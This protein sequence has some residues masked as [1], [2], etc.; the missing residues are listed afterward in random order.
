VEAVILLA[1]GAP[2]NLE[3]VEDYVMRIR[4]GRPLDPKLMADIRERYRL[5]GGSPL[6]KWTA[7]QAEALQESLKDQ[8]DPRKVYFGMRYSAPYIADTVNEMIRDGVHSATSICLAPQFSKLTIG[9][10][11]KAMQDA[12]AGREFNF[13]LVPTYAKHPRL[14]Q[15]FASQLQRTLK[16][17]PDAFVIFTAHSLPARVLTDGDPYDYEVKQ[18][19]LLVAQACKLPDWRFA[20]QSQGLTSEKWLGPTVESRLTELASKSISKVIIMPIGFVCDHVEILYDIDIQ[21]RQDAAGKGIEIFRPN[22]L[23]D[24]PGFIQL[25]QELCMR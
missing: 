4:H 19:A 2:E 7:R 6:R 14:I 16:D 13:R 3:D 25:L 12:I 20:Y 15:A 18:T 22:S 17:Q 8:N 21:F 23:N 9:A 5:I 1:H 11:E 24:S 10:Y